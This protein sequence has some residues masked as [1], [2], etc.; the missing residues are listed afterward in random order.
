M[1]EE[2]VAS[3]Q[4]NQLPAETITERQ[5][6]V[7]R[8][9]VQEYV[10]T[11]QPIGSATIARSKELD[12]SS[13]TIRNDLAALEQVGLLTH[14]HTSAGR[15]PTEAGYRYFVRYL[16]PKSELTLSERH[17]IRVQFG[18]ARPEI[19]QW[20][21]LSTSVLAQTTQAA[22]LATAPR[23]A[24]SRYKHLELVSIH[25]IRVLLVLVLQ[26]G[27]VK[28]QMIDVEQPMEQ[29]ELSRIS[30][31]L[32]E[33]LADFDVS[34]IRRESSTLSPFARQIAQ[35]VVELMDRSNRSSA[36]RI[37][38][39]GLGQMLSEPEFS[40]GEN[41]R[42]IVQV[43][44]EQTLLEQVVN[45]FV[46][47]DGIHV[48]ISG[49]GRFNELHDISLVLSRYGIANHTNGLLGVIGPLRMSYGRT[50]GAVSYVAR[51][52]SDLVADI[53]GISRELDIE[54]RESQ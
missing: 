1:A 49:D 41:M 32:N 45:E 30:N 36:G 43:L 46:E 8:I 22:A 16:L 25:D 44:E 20:L 5:K 12:V 19:D 40:D 7:L 31:E 18:Q 52:M 26:N 28:Q 35:L 50:M 47:L 42:S 27:A 23:S 29:P 34:A 39:D 24:Q 54:Q 9:L 15:V 53:Y 21:R 10:E 37:Y 6:Q 33:R 14:P 51:I 4:K 3:N 13:A 17:D 38:R 48:V 2:T 11:A